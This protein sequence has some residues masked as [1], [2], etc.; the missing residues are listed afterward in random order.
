MGCDLPRK[1]GLQDRLL[2]AI[3]LAIEQDLPYDKIL[4]VLVSGMF[5]RA[6][7]EDGNK[8]PQDIRFEKQFNK[9]TDNALQCDMEELMERIGKACLDK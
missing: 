1:L 4:Y 8:L 3:A 2:G 5:F 7:D 9:M 6:E